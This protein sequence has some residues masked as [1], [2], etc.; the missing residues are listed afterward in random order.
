MKNE[1]VG[2]FNELF[3]VEADGTIVNVTDIVVDPSN[4]SSL[5]QRVDANESDIDFL[6]QWDEHRFWT[7]RTAGGCIGGRRRVS[8][9]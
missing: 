9:R 8:D 1:D 5:E 6:K 4:L 2:I 3:I 7:A